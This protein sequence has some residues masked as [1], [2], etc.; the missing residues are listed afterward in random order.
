[1]SCRF[2]GTVLDSIFN[3]KDRI[4]PDPSRKK[5][6]NFFVTMKRLVYVAAI[7]AMAAMA[8]SCGQKTQKAETTEA[9]ETQQ[10]EVATQPV[11]ETTEEAVATQEGAQAEPE[12]ATE[13]VA[14]QAIN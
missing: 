10:I 7:V 3:T 2:V 11:E 12:A 4:V 6:L 9:A 8:V 5:G 13:T 1:M 14:E